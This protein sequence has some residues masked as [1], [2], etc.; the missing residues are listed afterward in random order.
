MTYYE[1]K[2]RRLSGAS[3]LRQD[4]KSLE[5]AIRH[6][7][8]DEVCAHI[9]RRIMDDLKRAKTSRRLIADTDGPEVDVEVTK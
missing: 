7:A 5:R 6:D 4:A 8:G 3:L 9:I 1:W 2:E